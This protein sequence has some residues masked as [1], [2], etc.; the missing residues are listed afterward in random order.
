MGL[1][2]R[3]RV[4]FVVVL[5]KG[6]AGFGGA[7]ISRI[8]WHDTAETRTGKRDYHGRAVRGKRFTCRPTGHSV[9]ALYCDLVDLVESRTW[10]SVTH[11]SRFCA[12]GARKA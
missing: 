8:A 10:M 4:E 12:E 11:S 3:R 6:R 7:G 5:L 2:V 1:D 9:R